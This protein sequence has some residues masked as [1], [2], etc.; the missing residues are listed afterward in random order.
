MDEEDVAEIVEKIMIVQTKSKTLG[1]LLKIPKATLDSIFQQYNSPNDRLFGVIDEF[2]K[3]IDPKPT[4]KV[5]V[6]ALRSPLLRQSSLA[7]KLE[8]KYCHP[9]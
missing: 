4:W 8:N 6:A 1:R 5:I 3:Q 9:G 2:V 7:N